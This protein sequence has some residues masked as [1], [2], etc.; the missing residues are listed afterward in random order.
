MPLCVGLFSLHA[1]VAL[2]ANAFWASVLGMALLG[3]FLPMAVGLR[4]I[5]GLSTPRR[6]PDLGDRFFP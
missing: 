2:L 3:S 6:Q 4:W 1:G 5:F